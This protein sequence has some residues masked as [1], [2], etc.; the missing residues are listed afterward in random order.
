MPARDL[1]AQLE[2]PERQSALVRMRQQ[3]IEPG[4]ERE[5]RV[6][7]GE[8]ELDA[9]LV[10]DLDRVAHQREH[11]FGRVHERFLQRRAAADDAGIGVMIEVV[12]ARQSGHRGLR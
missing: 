6:V 2:A 4:D 7:L 3:Q 9:F 8:L 5:L 12:V 1:L 10:L 11:R